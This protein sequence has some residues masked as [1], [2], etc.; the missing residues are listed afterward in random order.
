MSPKLTLDALRAAI[1]RVKSLDTWHYA[2]S[3]FVP[4]GTV[5]V[6]RETEYT[7]RALLFHP[8]EFEPFRAIAPWV[9]WVHLRDAPIKLPS[10][11]VS[12]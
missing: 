4:A 1:E 7:H 10:L 2:E 9:R 11:E 12:K 5:L 8:G 3:E 6:M